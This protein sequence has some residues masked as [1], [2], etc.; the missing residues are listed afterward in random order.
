MSQDHDRNIAFCVKIFLQIIFDNKWGGMF[1]PDSYMFLSEERS[2]ER[3]VSQG[4][5]S[6]TDI[7]VLV[8][9]SASLPVLLL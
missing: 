5:S 3:S 2:D 8:W 6:Y 9:L 1:F 4:G 7:K